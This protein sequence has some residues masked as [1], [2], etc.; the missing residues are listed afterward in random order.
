MKTVHGWFCLS[1]L[2][3]LS[4]CCFGV[5]EHDY[6]ALLADGKK[7]GYAEN[8]RKV[9]SGRVVTSQIMNMSIARGGVMLDVM[10]EETY[11]ESLS[12]TPLSFKAVQDL[13]IMATTVMGTRNP[14]GTFKV[15]SQD[16]GGKRVTQ[17]TYPQ[18]AL[19]P[20]ALLRLQLK[21]GLEPGT[22]GQAKM[23]SPAMLDAVDIHWKVLGEEET[24]LF[25]RVV[26]LHKIEASMQAPTGAMTTVTWIDEKMRPFKMQVPMMGMQ[27]EMILCDESVAKAPNDV[28]DFLE[29]TILQS[30][31]PLSEE[32]LRGGLVYSI[33]SS[34]GKAL[35][36]I[37]TGE[38]TVQTGQKGQYTLTVKPLGAGARG[39]ATLPIKSD[40]PEIAEA[41]KPSQYVQSDDP[42]VIKLAQKAVGKTK[43][44]DEAAAKIEAFVDQFIS[45][46]NLSVGY[47]TAAEVA[48]SGQGDCTE[49]AVLTAAMCRAVGIPARV[50]SGLVYSDS[51]FPG[52]DIFGGHAWA[53]YYNGKTWIGLDA[54]RSDL[55]GFDAGHIAMATGNGEPKDFFGMINTLGNFTIEKIEPVK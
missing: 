14:D 15:V 37:A 34:D 12:G 42:D 31:R 24:D 46:K 27:L 6:Y 49:H 47:A 7:I 28:V 54:T 44:V 38:Q 10:S 1:V 50:V 16:M 51:F 18:G 23:F 53:E 45:E 5:T 19:M 33:V 55:G 39:G 9:Q 41:L 20:E 3:V 35:N 30:P 2:A 48:E 25:G 36:F 22:A 13:G 29:K 40:S 26:N 8:I 52:R 32:E 21:Q 43:D 11:T 4:L 17:Y